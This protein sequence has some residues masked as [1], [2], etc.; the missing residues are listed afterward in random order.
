MAELGLLA[1]NIIDNIEQTSL[2]YYQNNEAEAG[3]SMQKLITN[4]TGFVD[5]LD[6]EQKINEILD[7]LREALQAM[8]DR[9]Y[10]YLADLLKYEI[11]EIISEYI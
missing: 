10:V 8:E 3:K 9:D 7:R 6:D 1:R 11:G 4:L 5:A 2:L